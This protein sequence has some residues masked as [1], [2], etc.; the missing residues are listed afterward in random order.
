M[1]KGVIEFFTTMWSITNK[2]VTKAVTVV[3]TFKK[4]SFTVA[5]IVVIGMAFGLAWWAQKLVST[6]IRLD[7]ALNYVTFNLSEDIKPIEKDTKP[8]KLE[9]LQFSSLKIYDFT[10]IELNPKQ[11]IQQVEPASH[12]VPF[13]STSPVI[14]AGNENSGSNVTIENAASTSSYLGSLELEGLSISTDNEVTLEVKKDIQHTI[15]LIKIEKNSEEEE[16]SFVRLIYKEKEHFSLETTDSKILNTKY[17]GDFTFEGSLKKI[18]QS[19][20]VQVQFP[21]KLELRIPSKELVPSEKFVP[22]E[23]FDISL[24]SKSGTH[25]KSLNFISKDRIEDK[26]IKETALIKKGEI[27]YPEYPKIGKVFLEDSDFLVSDKRN[28]FI[29]EK[30][31]INTKNN[32]IKLR[33]QGYV[34]YPIHTYP[35]GFLNRK[36]ERRLTVYDTFTEDRFWMVIF[37]FA[38]WIIQVVIGILGLLIVVRVKPMGDNAKN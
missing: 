5:V 23:E 32:S 12:L 6:Q 22:S 15:I 21:V 7:L 4:T 34:E 1:L 13:S 16:K 37:N 20:N 25:I 19:I 31:L 33:L 11:L 29:I 26:I 3:A 36:K 9:S 24:F 18:D 10:S 14:L 2:V 38:V 8:I 30:M 28:Q 35:V 17:Q 27:S